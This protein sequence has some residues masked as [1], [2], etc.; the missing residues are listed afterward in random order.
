MST[1]IVKNA[2]YRYEQLKPLVFEILSTIDTGLIKKNGRVLIKP[3]LL[4]P[5]KPDTAMLT[6]PLVIRATAEYVLDQGAHPQI[7]DSPAMGSFDKIVKE[8]GIQEALSGLPVAYREFR[9]S[10]VTDI[11]PPFHRIEIAEDALAADVIINLPKLKTHSQMLLTL[12]VKNMFGCIVGL[13]KPEWHFRTGIDREMFARLLV[14]IYKKLT[15]DFTILDGVSAME[16][17]GPGRSGTPKQMNV[18]MGSRDAIALDM[19]VCRVLRIDPDRVLTN[20]VA[21]DAGLSSEPIDFE[22]ELPEIKHFRLPDITP[23]V[24]GP[25]RLHGFLRRHLVQRPVSDDS[26]CRLCDEC[27]RYCPADAI[28]VSKNKVAFDYDRCIRCY[29]CIEVCPHG[30]LRT[31]ESIYGKIIRKLLNR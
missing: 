21:K 5:A 13:K 27:V 3:N 28:S 2:T 19:T 11:G 18:L 25:E 22:G 31:R 23:V 17:Q 30:A 6:H 9:Q 10:A 26:L 14:Q 15:P 1:V 24:F 4:A 20:K 8:S 29:C 16:G 7:S 12:G